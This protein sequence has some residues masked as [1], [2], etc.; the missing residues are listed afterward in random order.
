MPYARASL[1]DNRNLAPV[2]QRASLRECDY[3][4]QDKQEQANDG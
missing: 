1:G 2:A 4:S 3:H